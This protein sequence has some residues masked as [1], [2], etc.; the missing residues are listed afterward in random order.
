[1]DT[2]NQIRP[3]DNSTF[4]G[5]ERKFISTSFSFILILSFWCDLVVML[6]HYH[7]HYHDD[8]IMLTLS[9]HGGWVVEVTKIVRDSEVKSELSYDLVN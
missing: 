7:Y 5:K 1:M 4:T 8:I 9:C 6:C 3:G 2:F